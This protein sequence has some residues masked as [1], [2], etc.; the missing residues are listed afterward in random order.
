[1]AVADYDVVIVGAGIAG[2][3][4]SLI[5]ARAGRRTRVLT[6]PALG[7]QLLSIERIDG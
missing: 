2:L 7:G 4:A 3:T 6:G 5:S 1:M